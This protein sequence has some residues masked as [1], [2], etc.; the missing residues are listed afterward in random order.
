ML[1]KYV[2][3]WNVYI[4][5][6]LT[7]KNLLTSLRVITELQNPAMRGRHWYQLMEAIGVSIFQLLLSRPAHSFASLVR[8]R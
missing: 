5:L 7:I 8:G 4:G 2:R 6:E 1:D 3:P